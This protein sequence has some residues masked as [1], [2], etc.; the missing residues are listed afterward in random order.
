M[1][2]LWSQ[3]LPV[4]QISRFDNFFE[5]GGH[6]L[7][8]TQV[9]SRV[10][11]TFRIELPLRTMFVAPTLVALARKIDSFTQDLTITSIA[12]IQRTSRVGDLPLSFAQQRLWFLDQW[13]PQNSFY[14]M[15]ATVSLKGELNRAA[16]EYAF[17]AIVDRHEV[18]RTTF[19]FSDNG[20][21][22]QSIAPAQVALPLIDLSDVAPEAQQ[23]EVQRLS[24]AEAV[25]P[26]DL[27]QGPLLRVS[28]V[29]LDRNEHL[30]FATM[31]HIVSDG[32]SM[33]VLTNE[34]AQ[35]YG[36]FIA[37]KPATLPELPIQYADYALWQRE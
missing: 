18:L 22:V 25:H 8:A 20:A 5:L 35:L 10:R 23:R 6:S 1:A 36:S 2:A 7:L 3:L 9:I 32:W 29:C 12:S 31:H 26:F 16:L 11:E 37:G 14:N 17:R 27:A 4:K 21:P 19:P 30:L 24:R 34:L 33:G 15:P 13:A 28:L